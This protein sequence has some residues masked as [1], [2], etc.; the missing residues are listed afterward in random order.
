MILIAVL[1]LIS[2]QDDPKQSTYFPTYFT[3][4]S[5]F[6]IMFYYAFAAY[7]THVYIRANYSTAPLAARPAA[8]RYFG[9]T[10]YALSQP[11]AYIVSAVFWTVLAPHSFA[12]APV[13]ARVLTSLIHSTNLLLVLFEFGAGGR[14]P[15]LY[16]QW[17]PMIAL[18][19][20]YL[21]W[22][23]VAHY[24]YAGVVDPE[25]Y[26]NGFW[27]YSFLRV[28]VWYSFII[29]I[30]LAFAFFGVHCF[31]ACIHAARDRRRKRLGKAPVPGRR[32]NK[33]AELAHA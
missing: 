19:V 25:R 11:Y 31:A 24:A 21:L 29:Y 7:S 30:I 18:A 8:V 26:P 17:V 20:L 33:S 28:D 12:N 3:H 9:W 5:W 27:A 14:L 6:G 23:I 32:Q 15:L 2:P 22:S 10:L 4:L 16:V 1:T 13:M